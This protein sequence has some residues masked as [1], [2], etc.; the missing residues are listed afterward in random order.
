[1][2]E[3]FENGQLNGEVI[4]YYENGGIKIREEYR[5]QEKNG[6]YIRYYENGSVNAIG[7]LKMANLTEIGQ[8]FMKMEN[9]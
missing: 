7:I 3:E 2:C 4:Y 6:K 5:D 8:C 1:M 9:C